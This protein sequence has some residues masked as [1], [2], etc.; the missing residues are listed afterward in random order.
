M[1]TEELPNIITKD[2]LSELVMQMQLDL[3]EAE[4]IQKQREKEKIEQDIAEIKKI[5]TPT[6]PLNEYNTQNNRI[7]E[8]KK[9]IPEL[10]SAINK[11][12]PEIKIAKLP[13]AERK[14]LYH[15][16]NAW[17]ARI[18]GLGVALLTLSFFWITATW[19]YELGTFLGGVVGIA[20]L[21]ATIA[22]II[23]FAENFTRKIYLFPHKYF[24]LPDAKEIAQSPAEL[25]KIS[26]QW[27]TQ[28]GLGRI[29]LAV[30]RF[31]QLLGQWDNK[32]AEL[33]VLFQQA[34]KDDN[35]DAMEK[36]TWH[37]VRLEKMKDKLKERLKTLQITRESLLS[38]QAYDMRLFEIEAEINCL[39]E[40]VEIFITQTS[41]M[42]KKIRDTVDLALSAEINSILNENY[43]TD[44]NH[45]E[46]LIQKQVELG[47][48]LLI[49]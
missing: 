4:K 12:L 39:G 20:G 36:V 6:M 49:A 30:E 14:K 27:L 33:K 9:L 43:D 28:V 46:E 29:E 35:K 2:E 26:H 19:P 3:I 16:K 5:I 34:K 37:K 24:N 48:K 11:N 31:G 21:I 17:Y 32:S 15:K 42:L 1:I 25:N 8:L 44:F 41:Q 23:D 47:D 10:E 45:L 22:G 13:E 7:G 40:D 18:L 38:L